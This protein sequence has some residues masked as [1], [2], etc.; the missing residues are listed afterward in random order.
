M[1]L[2][3]APDTDPLDNLAVVVEGKREQDLLLAQREQ[4][5]YLI[6]E[7]PCTPFVGG[8]TVVVQEQ[9]S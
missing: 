5:N 6:L 9:E 8:T 1:T 4:H 7:V 3:V 2:I